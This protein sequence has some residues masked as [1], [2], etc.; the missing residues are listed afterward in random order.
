MK[1][2]LNLLKAAVIA[3]ILSATFLLTLFLLPSTVSAITLVDDVW[4]E[5]SCEQCWG[6]PVK[7]VWDTNE[8]YVTGYPSIR[9]W[10]IYLKFDISDVPDDAVITSTELNLYQD[11]SSGSLYFQHI[12]QDDWSEKSGEE[13]GTLTYARH[14]D[15][16]DMVVDHYMA[17]YVPHYTRDWDDKWMTYELSTWDYAPDLIDDQLTIR[18]Q[19]GIL[20]DYRNKF[21]S[22]EYGDGSFGAYLDVVTEP[23]T[24]IPEPATMLLLGSG[25]IGL[26]GFR[27]KKIKN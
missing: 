2:K 4:V 6:Y 27:R 18:I 16:N 26:A 20:D 14:S 21:Y 8:L 7:Q 19:F 3:F 10:S 11:F 13:Y 17:P 22:K 12:E 5:Y 23:A 15:P 9:Y 25:L 1:K 24:V